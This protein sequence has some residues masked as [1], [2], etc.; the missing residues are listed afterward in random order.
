MKTILLLGLFL[1]SAFGCGMST[2]NEASQRAA[3]WY[4]GK[5]SEIINSHRNWVQPGSFFPDW[6]YNC[7]GFSSESEETHW[8]PFIN[9]SATYIRTKYQQPWNEDAQNTISF[10]FGIMSHSVA[11][12][13]WHSLS[14]SEGLIEAMEHTEFRGD[15]DAAHTKADIGG[16][17]VLK[18]M[19]DLSGNAELQWNIPTQD[20]IELYDNYFSGTDVTE[21]DLETC[22]LMGYAGIWGNQILG[23]FAFPFVRN[24]PLLVEEYE[25]YFLGG[26]NDMASWTVRCWEDFDKWLEG[27][28]V[29]PMCT[30]MENQ[31]NRKKTG[32]T[33]KLPNPEL[34]GEKAVSFLE[35]LGYK[36]VVSRKNGFSSVQL[37]REDGKDPMEYH[38]E[39]MKKLNEKFIQENP[40][41]HPSVADCIHEDSFSN[42]TLAFD[43]QA[44]FSQFG[45][46]LISG[47][48]NDDGIDDLV[49]GSPVYGTKGNPQ[50]GAVYLVYGS[51]NKKPSE[52][53][54]QDIAQSSDLI[55]Y[56]SQRSS[57]F[58]IFL[59]LFS[60]SPRSF[61]EKKKIKVKFK[62]KLKLKFKIF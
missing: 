46:S 26:M 16:E 56:G 11:D 40:D 18:R 23:D 38:K 35:S 9:M 24:A 10:F 5:S 52:Y 7:R 6:G 59:F 8:P 54:L 20:L 14:M 25:D 28:Q 12:N 4:D 60:F 15:W 19:K 49:I 30:L 41:I 42:S 17:F 21:N 44:K 29:R 47:D 1:A 2:H 50:T 34:A 48:F 62:S 36:L 45:A 53:L 33:I 55:L 39:Q 61:Y 57:K 31:W 32:P 51:P 58:G 37:T 27:G 13:S 22:L 3:Y 43:S